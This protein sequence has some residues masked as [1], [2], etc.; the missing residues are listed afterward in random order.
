MKRRDGGSGCRQNGFDSCVV[1]RDVRAFRTAVRTPKR[2]LHDLCGHAHT[3]PYFG[4]ACVQIFFWCAYERSESF[5]KAVHG[6]WNRSSTEMHPGI[7]ID[8][9][10]NGGEGFKLGSGDR[11]FEWA[12][13]S[14]AQDQEQGRVSVHVRSKGDGQLCWLTNERSEACHTSPLCSFPYMSRKSVRYAESRGESRRDN[15][16]ATCGDAIAKSVTDS[17]LDKPRR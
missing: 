5:V 12:V 9:R 11:R 3:G 13:R 8:R 1:G 15:K 16:Y 6:S 4:Q 7:T 17:A 2:G 14:V 10:G